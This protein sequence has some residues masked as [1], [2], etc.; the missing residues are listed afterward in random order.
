[1]S[2]KPYSTGRGQ[3]MVAIDR[4]ITETQRWAYPLLL[5]FSG[6]ALGVSG[7]PAPLYGIYETA[8][9]LTPLATTIIFAVYALAALAAVLVSGRISDVIGRKPVLVGAL[10]AMLIGLGVFLVADNMA[11][12]LLA[13]TI[14]GA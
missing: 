7:L 14:H 3:P 6:V 5:I 4:P 12:L 8:W 9:H 1:M 11:L 13:R 2:V 10:I